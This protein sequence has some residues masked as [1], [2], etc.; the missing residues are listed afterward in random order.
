MSEGRVKLREKALLVVKSNLGQLYNFI[1]QAD[2][3][4]VMVNGPDSIWIERAGRMEQTDV[5]ISSDA[6][7]SAITALANINEKGT[8]HLL[9]L[10]LPHLRIAATLTPIALGGPSLCIRR[11]AARVL[12]LDHYVH[13]GAFDNAW[14]NRPTT[15]T[16]DVPT[17]AEIA[18][19]GEHLARFL[20]HLVL[21]QTPF[22]LAGSTSSG[23]TTLLNALAAEIPP[24]VRVGTIE[25]TAELQISVPNHF[26]F[27]ANAAFGITIRSLLKHS[28]RYRPQMLLIG[29]V[30]GAEAFDMLRAFRTGHPGFVSYH[31]DSCYW[32]LLQLENMVRTAAEA[33][34]WMLPDLRR[35][36]AGTFRYV[37]HCREVV[38]QRAPDELI[39]VLGAENGAYQYRTLFQKT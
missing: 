5:N 34:N 10:K 17:D 35:Q 33:V 28:L 22:I 13:T 36:I 37:M 23:K 26:G 19:G 4:E 1:E 2:V 30:R 7:V 20:R 14:K 8:E 29:E 9:D 11:H 25:D 16:N 3:Q 18:Q 38:G 15:E 32:A 39:E 31:A 21:S 24:H 27:E 6:L 12:S